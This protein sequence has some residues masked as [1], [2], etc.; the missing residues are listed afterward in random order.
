MDTLSRAACSARKFICSGQES[1][2]VLN[3]RLSL[4]PAWP[5]FPLPSSGELKKL[6][7][8]MT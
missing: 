1:H 8:R 5:K 7:Q 2:R 4:A 6:G 3:S